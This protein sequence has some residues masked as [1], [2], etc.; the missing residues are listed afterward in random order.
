VNFVFVVTA[1]KDSPFL[2]MLVLAIRGLRK[3]NPVG[4]CT[5]VADTN[6]ISFV[7]EALDK[8]SCYPDELLEVKGLAGDVVTKSRHIKTTLRSIIKGDFV[9]LDVDAVPVADLSALF[10]LDCDFAAVMNVNANSSKAA[11]TEA[12]IEPFQKLRIEQPSGPYFNSGVFF[13]ADNIN[14]QNMFMEWHDQWLKMMS[15][16]FVKDQPPLSIALSKNKLRIKLL[17]HQYNATTAF[18]LNGAYR[19]KVL[20]Y[21]TVN[22]ENRSDTIFHQIVKIMR[23]QKILRED[24]FDTAVVEGYYWTDRNSIRYLIATRRYAALIRQ[25]FKRAIR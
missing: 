6:S 23:A 21:S 13:A 5:V 1:D 16:G 17:S 9:F 18:S 8:W 4:R 12:E 11:W 22:F 24:I 10:S 25:I 14:V 15:V 20:H 3:F 2:E 19:P 7:Q